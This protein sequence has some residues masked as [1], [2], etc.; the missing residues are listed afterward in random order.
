MCEGKLDKVGD[1]PQLIINKASIVHNA[2][3]SE[4]FDI[5]LD[6]YKLPDIV[7]MR[8]VCDDNKGDTLVSFIVKGKEKVIL[9]TS[10][11]VNLTNEFI[12]E[13]ERLI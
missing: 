11:A 9:E 3:S 1:I 4:T 10:C 2:A 5:E 7:A 8:K 12:E 13:L 6:P